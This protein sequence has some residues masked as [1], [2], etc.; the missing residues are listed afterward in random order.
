MYDRPLNKKGALTAPFLFQST[1]PRSLQ[2]G[3][4]RD[5]QEQVAQV[6]Q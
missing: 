1:Q 5:L 4:I 3:D 2:Q 6:V